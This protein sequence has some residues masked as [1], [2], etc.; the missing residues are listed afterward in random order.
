MTK[1]HMIRVLNEIRNELYV[2]I[3]SN[4]SQDF[5]NEGARNALHE[6]IRFIERGITVYVPVNDDEIKYF[7]R[8]DKILAVKNYHNR[9]GHSLR[10]SKD[11]VFKQ[12]ELIETVG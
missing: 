11:Q 9:T 12:C 3:A 5:N 1:E 2:T 10:V 8:G 4:D 7:C 6:A